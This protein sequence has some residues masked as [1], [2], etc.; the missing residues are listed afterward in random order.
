[1]NSETINY[2]NIQKVR[3]L[4]EEKN[5]SIPF[6]ATE[7]DIQDVITDMDHFV[8]T[9][10]FRGQFKSDKPIVMEREAGFRLR[11][12]NCYR[13]VES[14]C[15]IKEPYPIH[16]YEVPCSTVFPCYPNYLDK[17]SDRNAMNV[18]INNKCISDYR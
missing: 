8:Y 9:R 6:Y 4:I 1:M 5:K 3:S 18:M 7:N 11:H 12:D 17:Y 14:P 10:F 15:K 2:N 16:C 13:L